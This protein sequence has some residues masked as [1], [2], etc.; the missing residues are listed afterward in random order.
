[1][2]GLDKIEQALDS[3]IQLRQQ[4]NTI[5]QIVYNGEGK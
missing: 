3:N 4:I 1:M 5:T 2:H